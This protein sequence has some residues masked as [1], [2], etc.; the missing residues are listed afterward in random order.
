MKTRITLKGIEDVN[1]VLKELAPKH[2]KNI[3]RAT[4]HDVAKKV[5]A[6]SREGMPEDEGTMIKATKH[7]RERSTR[8]SVRSTVRVAR[9]AFYWRFLEY[10]DGPDGVAYDF[11]FNAVQ[12]MRAKLPQQFLESF[13]DKFEAALARAKKRQAK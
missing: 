4:V 8:T 1:E 12:R 10:G 13:K 3:M 11:F 5:A 6:D 7:K 9:T 2:A